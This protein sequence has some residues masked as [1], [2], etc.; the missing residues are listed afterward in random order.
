MHR[1]GLA[2]RHARLH[3]AAEIVRNDR[4]PFVGKQIESL[5]K[6]ILTQRKKLL[7]REIDH[8]AISLHDEVHPARLSAE[9]EPTLIGAG[10]I[11]QQTRA[12]HNR[13]VNAVREQ[14]ISELVRD[15][16]AIVERD[17]DKAG[18]FLDQ[19]GFGRKP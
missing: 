11:G 15:R 13:R 8:L 3:A 4:R 6:W 19:V 9:I 14:L 18:V 12:A 2:S 5:Q 7:P 16:P 17:F 10:R 1:T